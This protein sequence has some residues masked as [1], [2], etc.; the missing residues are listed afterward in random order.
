MCLCFSV[1]DYVVC[2]CDHPSRHGVSRRGESF[3]CDKAI[4]LDV[5]IKERPC[6]WIRRLLMSQKSQRTC[7]QGC[8]SG[9]VELVTGL[10]VFLRTGN[11][12]LCL[13]RKCVSLLWWP[14][15]C[16]WENFVVKCHHIADRKDVKVWCCHCSK[17]FV[18]KCVWRLYCRYVFPDLFA[19]QTALR[20]RLACL[21]RGL[22]NRGEDPWCEICI[23]TCLQDVL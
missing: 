2:C 3:V 17:D 15:G 21:A 13:L 14:D 16:R 11:S 18:S 6:K 20:C 7:F 9:I 12:Y 1:I 8:A 19:Y 22:R 23:L 10:L 4:V 5:R